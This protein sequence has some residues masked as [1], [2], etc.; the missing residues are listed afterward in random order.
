MVALRTKQGMLAVVAIGGAVAVGVVASV[1][2]L[3]APPPEHGHGP[4]DA[5]SPPAARDAEADDAG[6]R[7]RRGHDLWVDWNGLCEL[8]DGTLECCGESALDGLRVIGVRGVWVGSPGW[9]C[10]V[11]IRGGGECLFGR[12]R[13]AI[14]PETKALVA[15]PMLLGGVCVLTTSR[16]VE[17]LS[18][19]RWDVV[20]EHAEA[21]DASFRYVFALSSGDIWCWGEDSYEICAGLPARRLTHVGDIVALATSR[22]GHVCGLREGG[23]VLC[24]GGPAASDDAWWGARAPEGELVARTPR[25]VKEIAPLTWLRRVGFATF[26]GGSDAPDESLWCW[27]IG[28]A[29]LLG[30]SRNA[31]VVEEPATFFRG[32]EIRFDR[33]VADVSG[34]QRLG[35]YVDPEGHRTCVTTVEALRDRCGA[36][37]VPEPTDPPPDTA[38]RPRR[39]PGSR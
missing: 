19:G 1:M 25:Y 3:R 8:V 12:D 34:D 33:P 14:P 9:L 22:A 13:K 4:E 39:R 31:T 6:A 27:G 32:R 24:W 29:L 28:G 5:G 35:C 38:A 36:R 18:D 30:L 15:V 10:H 7:A 26:C 20:M 17:C 23:A 37:L 2:M 16:T 21:L 11:G